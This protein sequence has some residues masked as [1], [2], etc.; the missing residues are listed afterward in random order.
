[1]SNHLAESL[2]GSAPPRSD[3]SNSIPPKLPALD[4]QAFRRKLAGL[5]DPDRH[6]G[7]AERS[8]VREAA[9]RLCSVLSH[10]FGEGL[11]RL[12]LWGRIGSAVETA[13]AKVS[14]DDLDRFADLC[15]EHVQA[16]VGRAAACDALT[17]LRQTWAVRPP[18][19]RYALLTY[20]RQHRYAVIQHGRAR[21]DL[22]KKGEAE[23]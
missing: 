8:E 12:T 7:E 21:W 18:E 11:D 23:L 3:A 10:L 16:D 22:V 19:W 5:A 15:L 17:T 9:I 13:C 20:C 6:P 14:D 1:M 2:P 4:Y